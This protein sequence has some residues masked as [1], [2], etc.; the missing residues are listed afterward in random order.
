MLLYLYFKKEEDEEED[1]ACSK[2]EG[3]TIVLEMPIPRDVVGSVIGRGGANIKEVERKSATRINFKVEESEDSKHRTCVIRGR[4]EDCEHAKALVYQIM[5]AL[6]KLRSE[7]VWV[8]KWSCGRII[9]R[10]GDTIRFMTRTS[11]ATIKLEDIVED[12]RQRIMVRGETADIEVAKKLIFEKVAEEQEIRSEIRKYAENRSPRLRGT[13]KPLLFLTMEEE[14]A[15]PP[16]DSSDRQEKLVATNSDGFMEVYVSAVEDAGHFWVQCVGPTGIEL[17]KLCET[18][19]DYYGDDENRE[20]HTLPQVN[21]GDIVAAPFSTDKCWYRARVTSIEGEEY[22]PDEAK[23]SVYFVD[24]GDSEQVARKDILEVRT[25]FLRLRFQSIECY[26]AKV[27][28][29]GGEWSEEATEMFQ[30]LSHAA[31]WR[32][33]M[34]SM[35]QYK[36]KEPGGIKVPC[37]ELLDASGPQ[38]INVGSELVKFGF[39]E[40]EKKPSPA[41][42]NENGTSESQSDPSLP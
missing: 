26:L 28:P 31:Q 11:K 12:G 34:A 36:E 23:V 29:R 9:G 38:D 2:R 13:R 7:E 22:D 42:A 35:V 24:Y 37:V 10:N 27:V 3:R 33:M 20:M 14:V 15:A 1:I 18:M 39:A 5:A 17:D 4:Q 6:P 21:V 19:T 25:D 30:E 32:V 40:W 41:A 16:P 8:P